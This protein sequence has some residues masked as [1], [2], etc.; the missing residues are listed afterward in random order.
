MTRVSQDLGRQG[1]A[2]AAA[3]L[4]KKGMRIRERNFR[5]RY[6]E[7]DL[8]ASLGPILVFIEVKTRSGGSFGQPQEAV[9]ARKQARLRRLA[10]YYL[11][12]VGWSGECRFDVV[13]VSVRGSQTRVEHFEEA[14]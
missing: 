8:I 7:I 4:E 6:G 12:R 1:E 9:E 3:M 10:A 2:A 14:F 13:A 11:A 5:T